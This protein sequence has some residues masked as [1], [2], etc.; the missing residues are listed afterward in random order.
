MQLQHQ[1]Q[2]VPNGKPSRTNRPVQFHLVAAMNSRS[3]T[4]GGVAA[5]LRGLDSRTQ[6]R[7]LNTTRNPNTDL[8]RVG[9][10]SLARLRPTSHAHGNANRSVVQVF[11]TIGAPT[12]VH[13][14]TG[15]VTFSAV[16]PHFFQCR[17]PV[18][19]AAA[20]CRRPATRPVGRPCASA[21]K[22]PTRNRL[23]RRVFGAPR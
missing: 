11:H 10:H 19:P 21:C 16:M 7:R 1:V 18:C 3:R 20:L 13:L 23:R 2:Q 15:P 9:A 4:A 22:I 17:Q 6:T 5:R 12:T 14:G 8:A